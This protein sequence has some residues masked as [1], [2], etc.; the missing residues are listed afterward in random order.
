MARVKCHSEREIPAT[1][2]KPIA[3][4]SIRAE[5]MISGLTILENLILKIV[6]LK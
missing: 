1:L 5:T 3:S 4:V 6:N 2:A